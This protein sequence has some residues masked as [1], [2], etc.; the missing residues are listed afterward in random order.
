MWDPIAASS[1]VEQH[2]SPLYCVYVVS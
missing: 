1:S 2:A